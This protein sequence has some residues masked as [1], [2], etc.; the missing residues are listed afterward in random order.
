MLP[1]EMQVGRGL[2]S[3]ET[4]GGL[5][6]SRRVFKING[7]FQMKMG[8]LTTFV[9]LPALLAEIV[10]KSSENINYTPLLGTDVL[11]KHKLSFEPIN[12]QDVIC[13]IFELNTRNTAIV[14]DTG[15]V[16][17]LQSHVQA[18]GQII[19]KHYNYLKNKLFG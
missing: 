18:Q 16:K 7:N 2:V 9:E 6:E 14:E 3:T 11:F 17:K 8:G 4:A 12:A 5:I 10:P 1:E 19:E 15:V 13:D